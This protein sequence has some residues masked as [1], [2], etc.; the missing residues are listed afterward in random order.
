MPDVLHWLGIKKIDRYVSMSNMKYDA[1]VN[2]GI[3][4]LERFFIN[5]RVEIPDDLVPDDAKVEMDAKVVAGYF[6]KK[7]NIDLEA[8]NKTKGRDL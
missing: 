2:S 3:K 4:I 5:L 8:L 1:I 7:S 6:T